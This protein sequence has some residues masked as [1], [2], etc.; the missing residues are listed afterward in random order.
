MHINFD[1]RNEITEKLAILFD[2]YIPTREKF[3][4]PYTSPDL[5]QNLLSDQLWVP[6]HSTCCQ[7]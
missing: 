5:V 7:P 2:F 3:E 6:G 1:L 4:P